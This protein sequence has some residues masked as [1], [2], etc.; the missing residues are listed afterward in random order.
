MS[1]GESL[2]SP[3]EES[4][5]NNLRDWKR[6]SMAAICGAAMLLYA[7]Y[8]GAFGVLLPALSAEFHLGTAAS[9][10]LFP[11]N[12]GGFV[13]GVLISGYA[14]DRA[15]RKTGTTSNHYVQ[16]SRASVDSMHL[17]RSRKVGPSLDL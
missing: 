6:I 17:R 8:L 12:F 5:N 10:R 4:S 1:A 2:L 14:S 3:S 7:V 9:G 13:A 11:A 15:G 16:T